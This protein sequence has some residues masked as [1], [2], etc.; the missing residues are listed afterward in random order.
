MNIFVQTDSLVIDIVRIVHIEMPARG[1]VVVRMESGRNVTLSRIEGEQLMAGIK[2]A[3]EINP[4]HRAV[5]AI[6]VHSGGNAL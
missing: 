1:N 4:A 6:A 3:S 2:R 5:I